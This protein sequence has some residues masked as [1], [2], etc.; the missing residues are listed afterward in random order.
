[1]DE[2]FVVRTWKKPVRKK[3]DKSVVV[4]VRME[5]ELRGEFDEL[6]KKSGYSR[7]ELLCM[8]LRYALDH[9]EFTP[10]AEE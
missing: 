4:S 3:D 1:M 5:K 2:G 7:N 10:D 9:L 8:A 6:A